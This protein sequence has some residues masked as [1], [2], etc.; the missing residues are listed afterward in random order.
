MR[1]KFGSLILFFLAFVL[2]PPGLAQKPSREAKPDLGP[3][4]TE[5][6][7]KVNDGTLPSVSIGVTRNGKTL[8]LESFGYADIGRKVPATP[9]TIYALGSLSKSI[10]A[11][12][13]FKLVQDGKI[14]LD[15]PIGRYLT[16]VK[17]DHRGRDPD[18]YKVFHLLNMAAGIPHYWRYCYTNSGPLDKC[19]DE[20]LGRATFSAFS[21]GA[22]H[23]YSNLSYGLAA[24][25]VADVSGQPLSSYMRTK[26]FGPAG[27]KNTITH[28]SGLPAYRAAIARP[29]RADGRLADQFQ[30]EPAGGGGYFSTVNDLLKYGSMHLETRGKSESVLKYAMQKEIHRVREGLPH[31]LYAN[32][33]GVLLLSDGRRTLLSNGAIEGAASTLLVLPDSGIV[34][35]V[36]INKSV[37]NDVSDDIAFRIAGAL[38][39][40]YKKDLDSLF[41]RVG[42]SFAS[43][44]L[45]ADSSLEGPWAG[46][47]ANAER[48]I[49]IELNFNGKTVTIKVDTFEPVTATPMREQGVITFS[50]DII[51]A[52][53]L[54][55][56]STDKLTFQ[57]PGRKARSLL[58]RS[59]P[60]YS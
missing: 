22:V 1:P 18:S 20:L 16:S 6:Q 13:V 36:L 38:L 34:I 8:W 58:V 35:V 24:Q 12:A 59:R 28:V 15:Q 41:E 32:G 10:T 2:V 9:D 14:D 57:L 30:F 40:G 42:P 25:M 23:T 52:G 48:R 21:A 60:R 5:L 51:G 53:K 56:A 33:W 54:L 27:M 4:R 11:T 43:S 26:I 44:E 17:I 29:Y 19:R 3:I 45:D 46:Y 49:P 47:V 39:P 50:A 31:E 55:R 37:G 7:K